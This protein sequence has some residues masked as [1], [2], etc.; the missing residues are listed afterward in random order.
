MALDHLLTTYTKINS[1]WI[2]DLNV[3]SKTIKILEEN[4]GSKISDVSCGNIFYDICPWSKE[5]IG[6]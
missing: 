5:T 6:K 2:T 1:K 3:N 4:T